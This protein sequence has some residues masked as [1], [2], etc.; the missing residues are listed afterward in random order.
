[1]ARPT[2]GG[3]SGRGGGGATTTGL[4]VAK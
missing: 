1:M 4:A 3:F 2:G